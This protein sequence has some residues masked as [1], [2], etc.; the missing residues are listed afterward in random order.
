MAKHRGLFKRKGSDIW[1]YRYADASG[2]IVR[3]SSFCTSYKKA[4]QKLNEIKAAI[5]KGIELE[6]HRKMGTLTFGEL[7][8]RYLRDVADAQACG[9]NKRYSLDRLQDREVIINGQAFKLGSLPLR[10]FTT[11]IVEQVKNSLR[12]KGLGEGTKTGLKAGSLNRVLNIIQNMFVKA[13]EWGLI[14]EVNLKRVHRVKL[15]KEAS[16]LRYLSKEEMQSLVNA[17]EDNIRPIVIC[18]L[19]TGMRK[20]EILKLT[21][22][23]IDLT[24]GFISLP[25]T[26]N[27][28]RRDV[29]INQTL[30][31]TLDRCPRRFVEKDGQRDLAPVFH[32]PE[33][34]KPRRN[35]DHS[36][37]L[38]LKAV[39]IKDFHFH[40]L[41]HTYASH[42]MM[43]G[44]IDIPTLSKLLGHKNL[45]MTM[46]YAHFSPDYLTK[47]AHV[48][49]AVLNL[50]TD[51]KLAQSQV[52]D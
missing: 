15:D 46:K 30:R 27:G 44:K 52:I 16:R 32:N 39:G 26:K 10:A 29:P 45:T 49:D 17:C 12:V 22:E 35:I 19:A 42:A 38:A 37:K 14:T 50:A 20:N 8:E 25:K 13:E 18:A 48:M 6:D 2:K 40:D 24:H 11:E 3:R 28:E 41:R 23:R 47:A 33:T 4:E 43:S 34:L 31:E 7:A 1:W 5:G 36:F 9:K 21:W 51:T